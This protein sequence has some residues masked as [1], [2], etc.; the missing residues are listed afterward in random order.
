MINGV[1]YLREG[2]FGSQFRAHYDMGYM[3]V[4]NA[5]LMILGIAQLRK[6]SREIVPE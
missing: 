1:E 6:V 5:A 2:Y 3:A 4:C